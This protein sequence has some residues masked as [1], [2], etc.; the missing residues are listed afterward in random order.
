MLLA[1]QVA[2]GFE[3]QLRASYQPVVS[4]ALL[5]ERTPLWS[6][7]EPTFL[8]TVTRLLDNVGL[9]L[10]HFSS[11]PQHCSW[12]MP[13]VGAGRGHSVQG[14][15]CFSARARGVPQ[16]GSATI[17][18]NFDFCQN[19]PTP[20]KPSK[21]TTGAPWIHHGHP[22]GPLW[23][24]QGDL[25]PHRKESKGCGDGPLQHQHPAGGCPHSM[26]MLA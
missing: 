21:Q 23:S 15:V 18:F 7:Y 3:Q 17:V 16:R 13:A 22:N 24:G 11:I 1:S 10:L 14:S 19:T 25:P 20:N 9:C 4:L 6:D 5:A 8:D 12:V 26:S 2:D